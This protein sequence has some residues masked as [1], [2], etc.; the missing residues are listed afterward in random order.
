MAEQEQV[1]IVGNSHTNAPAAQANEERAGD[2]KWRRVEERW[3]LA[4]ASLGP[5][6]SPVGSIGK[7]KR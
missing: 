5:E 7:P 4:I 1:L 6:R 2:W 3:A